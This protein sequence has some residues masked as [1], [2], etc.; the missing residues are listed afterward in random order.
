[1]SYA[2]DLTG[3]NLPA[4]H[5]SSTLGTAASAL[6]LA[7]IGRSKPLRRCEVVNDLFFL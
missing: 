7:S 4:Q 2:Y 3:G 1:M 5:Q 6:T